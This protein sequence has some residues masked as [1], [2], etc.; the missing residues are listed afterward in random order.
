[1]AD[2]RGSLMRLVGCALIIAAFGGAASAQ[3]EALGTQLGQ[4]R[5][6]R[7]LEGVAQKLEDFAQNARRIA[8]VVGVEEL[9]AAEA[10]VRESGLAAL[11]SESDIPQE[12]DPRRAYQE[13]LNQGAAELDAD[14]ATV[15]E[16]RD[17]VGEVQ[18]EQ[19]LAVLRE[20]TLPETAAR[21]L[22]TPPGAAVMTEP[23]AESLDEVAPP[24]FV[25]AVGDGDTQRSITAPAVAML[26]VD[27]NSKQR[28]KPFCSGVLIGPS[29]ILTAAHC[30]VDVDSTSENPKWNV[31]A[32]EWKNIKVLL[33]YAGIYNV[34]DSLPVFFPGFKWVKEGNRVRAP[35]HDLAVF[36][37]DKPVS[38]VLPAKVAS[39]PFGF[40][41][42]D[43][44][45]IFGYGY[46]RAAGGAGFEQLGFQ[47]NASVSARYCGHDDPRQAQLLCWLYA[48]AGASAGS[49]GVLGSDSPPVSSATFCK[50]DS[51]GP[52][53]ARRK[54]DD[55]HVVLG[56]HSF[57][58]KGDREVACK[59]DRKVYD[60]ALTYEPYQEWLN[61]IVSAD[62]LA[63]RS[64]AALPPFQVEGLQVDIPPQTI[65]IP[66]EGRKKLD[67][68]LELRADAAWITVTAATTWD[69][70]KDKLTFQ[71]QQE[72][73][74]RVS[75]ELSLQLQAVDPSSPEPFAS[76]VF[77]CE[78]ALDASG[79]YAACSTPMPE[80][81]RGKQLQLH[82]WGDWKSKVQLAIGVFGPPVGQ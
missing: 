44:L 32:K 63:D 45:T 41:P 34:S 56:V 21:V 30:F 73:Q 22:L 80:A 24:Q 3:E 8:D 74:D 77:D 78:G 57:V 75:M 18:P 26:L 28:L 68:P 54:A 47:A 4:A 58:D 61:G 19:V 25:T 15:R 55:Q 51:G 49:A 12:E 10:I 40:K 16:V 27:T 35:E 72:E 64:V 52:T 62:E 59:E 48:P 50:G 82:V 17:R 23:S 79:R 5:I 65:F 69:E 31:F 46:Y 6:V 71:E 66:R 38:T 42:E 70:P 33:H 60:V 29:T 9:A 2:E 14:S 76:P 81:A 53:V 37:L 67:A 36:R 13:A 1:M 39:R 11:V 43:R 7:E 20:R